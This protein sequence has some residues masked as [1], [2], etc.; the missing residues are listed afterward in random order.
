MSK[1]IIAL[2]VALI[3]IIA[4]GA[5]Y[6]GVR[7]NNRGRDII[8][9]TTL[10]KTNEVIM[11]AATGQE[12]ES[13]TGQITVGSGK[14][15]HLEYKLSAGSFDVAFHA[16]HGARDL[17]EAANMSDLSAEG[18]VF[19]KSSVSGSGSL[20]FEAAEGDYTVYF[21]IHDTIGTARVSTK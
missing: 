6:V 9:V 2:I 13:G 10:F 16:G 11:N 3:L 14:S 17:F 21:V 15:I 12:F 8:G 5:I 19:G 7:I 4:A 1:K 20:D 18:E